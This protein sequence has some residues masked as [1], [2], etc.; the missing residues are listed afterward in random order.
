MKLILFLPLL[1]LVSCEDKPVSSIELVS[2]VLCKV[3]FGSKRDL[4]SNAVSRYE[5]RRENNEIYC[6]DKEEKKKLYL[7]K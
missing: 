3:E 1:F 2:S 4:S 6:L 5:L 7:Q